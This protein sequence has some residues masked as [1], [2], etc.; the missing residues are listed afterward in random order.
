M[1]WWSSRSPGSTSLQAGW[2]E[3]GKASGVP[4]TVGISEACDLSEELA[5]ATGQR[6]WGYEIG[7]MVKRGSS[8]WG[9][10][11]DGEK[12]QREWITTSAAA[13]RLPPV[14]QGLF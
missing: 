6:W 9:A 13:V 8:F 3:A 10:D 1:W 7:S 4:V 5:D 11:E 14:Q 2:L 12:K